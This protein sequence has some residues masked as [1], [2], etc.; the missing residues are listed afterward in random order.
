MWSLS[1]SFSMPPSCKLV[2]WTSSL[3]TFANKTDLHWSLPNCSLHWSSW[4]RRQRDWLDMFEKGVSFASNAFTGNLS[5][6]HSRSF[7]CLLHGTMEGSDK[8]HQQTDQRLT[9][10]W[11][12]VTDVSL[13]QRGYLLVFGILMTL[14]IMY[15]FDSSCVCQT[16]QHSG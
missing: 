11:R 4:H 8:R 14:M 15:Y 6:M 10:S 3:D 9:I 12:P 2:N 16:F 7:T 1:P 5:S 13:I